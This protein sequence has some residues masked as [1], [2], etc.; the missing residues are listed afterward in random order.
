MKNLG[1]KTAKLEPANFSWLPLTAVE[2]T[3][4]LNSCQNG[5]LLNST[6]LETHESDRRKKWGL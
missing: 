5:I 6:K 1:D 4:K 2:T 3:E